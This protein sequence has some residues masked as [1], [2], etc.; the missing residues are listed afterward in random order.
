MGTQATEAYFIAAKLHA[1]VCRAC[2]A[3]MD[4]PVLLDKVYRTTD[5]CSFNN[6]DSGRQHEMKLP[7]GCLQNKAE[8]T[9]AVSRQPWG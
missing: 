5:T 7:L 2:C 3:E 1:K 4:H 8:K 6:L 9:G